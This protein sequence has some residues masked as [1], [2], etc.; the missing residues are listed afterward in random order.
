M[1][2]P[3]FYVGAQDNKDSKKLTGFVPAKFLTRNGRYVMDP[4]PGGSQNAFLYSDA[5]GSDKTKGEVAN[6]N[7]Y[8]IVPENHTEQNARDFAARI[9]DTWGNTQGDETGGLAGL[10]QAA[11]EMKS[12]FGQGGSQDLQRNPQWGIPNGS[13]VPAF[14]GSASDHLGYVTALGGLPAVLA[15]IAGGYV[16][17]RNAGNQKPSDPPIDA[18]GP[19]G[20][21]WHN[22]HNITQGYS[23]GIAAS[24]PPSPFNDYGNDSQ[25]ERTAGQIGDGNGIAGWL[26]ALPGVDPDEPTPS[27]WP[28]L[29]DQ[30]IRYLGRRTQ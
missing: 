2:D 20:L 3:V 16:N 26:A 17:K 13:F 29:A 6:P 12:A 22:Y 11:M 9:A 4:M 19:H 27:A 18:S 8:L 30:P 1:P 10:I 15:E 25:S 5:S 24:Q 28:P 21:S 7:N 23:D 14:T